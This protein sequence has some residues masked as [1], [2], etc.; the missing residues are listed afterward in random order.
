MAF[1]LKDVLQAAGP[2]ASLIFASWIFLQLLGQKYISAFSRYRTLV[3]EYRNG[4]ADDTRRRHL[5]EQIPLYKRRCEQM[6]R[7]TVIGVAAA[8]LL[9]FPLLAG[10]VETIV[11]N[12]S[13]LLKWAGAL[14]TV[15]G[16]SLLLWAAVYLLLENRNVVAA[17]HSEV[18]DLPDLADKAGVRHDR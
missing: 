8:T 7:A 9:I 13:L 11:G 2:T 14:S 12:E 10:T 15:L 16:L 4:G 17:L 1:Q 6:Q 5:A 18:K 3:S